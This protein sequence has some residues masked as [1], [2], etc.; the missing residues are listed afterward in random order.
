MAAT[1]TDQSRRTMSLRR[2]TLTVCGV[3]ALMSAATG[4]CSGTSTTAEDDGTTTTS[5]PAVVDPERPDGEAQ[6]R[7][8]VVSMD[9]GGPATD[10][11]VD[12]EVAVN[13][14][15]PQVNVP[16]E[17]VTAYLYLAPGT[18]DVA[19][20]PTGAGPE[21]AVVAPVEVPMVAAHRYLVAIPG[22]SANGNREPIVIDETEATADIGAEPT[23]AVTITLNDLAGTTGLDYEWAGELIN[24]D[25][26]YGGFEAATVS[27]GGGHMT[28]TATGATDTVLLDEENYVL[29]ADR[30][31]A[32]YGPDASSP[33]GWAITESAPTSELGVV[34]LLDAFDENHLGAHAELPT[35]DT[36]T[37]AI[38]TA[39]LDDLYKS[40]P[41]LFL[42]PTDQAFAEMPDAE[43]EALLAD[44]D[45][46]AEMLRAHTIEAYVPPGSLTPTPET[47][48]GFDRTFTNLLGDTIHVGPDF[49]INGGSSHGY[50]S[51]WLTNGTQVHP[52]GTVSF[53]IAP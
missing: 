36:V 47:C 38:E 9:H 27:P 50:S 37:A 41:L 4:A 16:A 30:V 21:A 1:R 35:F 46:L 3:V 22:G 53:P 10:L 11:F 28:I 20:A 19:V 18:H 43:R 45:A 48:C 12:G 8:H 5:E 14:G 24:D 52:V 32:F 33:T 51:V 7:V 40:D 13:G 6:A 39:G 25:I 31:V 44:P 34:E 49:T 2:R 23:D 15:Q 29:P 42:P 26:P 17:Y